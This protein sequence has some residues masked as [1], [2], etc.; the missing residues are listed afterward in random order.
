MCR[1]GKDRRKIIGQVGTESILDYRGR[2]REGG[3]RER[4]KKRKMVVGVEIISRL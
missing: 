4:N 3:E 1:F 2:E